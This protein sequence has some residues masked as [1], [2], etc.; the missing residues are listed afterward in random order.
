MT[1]LIAGA[2]LAPFILWWLW[3]RSERIVYQGEALAVLQT[4]YIG[5]TGQHAFISVILPG[6]QW[7][8][9]EIP[10]ERARKLPDVAENDTTTKPLPVTVEVRRSALGTPWVERV[11]F[12]EGRWESDHKRADSLFVS[13]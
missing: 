1:I 8:M 6:G 7:V 12:D 13:V 10:V 2:C 4:K 3:R 5:R 9:A 11:Q